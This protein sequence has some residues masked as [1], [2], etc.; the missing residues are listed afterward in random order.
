MC[1]LECETKP[2]SYTDTDIRLKTS[3]HCCRLHTQSVPKLQPYNNRLP[4]FA[5][6]LWFCWL[7]LYIACNC[8]NSE[9]IKPIIVHFYGT[10]IQ[11]IIGGAICVNTGNIGNIYGIIDN[12]CVVY[13]VGKCSL[14]SYR[15]HP[16][17]L[18]GVRMYNLCP[19]T[20][21]CA[22]MASVSA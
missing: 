2:I 9:N 14:N 5:P 7:F 10:N 20:L 22:S 6:F 19:F 13:V 4:Y 12:Y 1:N 21:M 17:C 8:I 16:Y 18:Y 15:V 11:S 3:L